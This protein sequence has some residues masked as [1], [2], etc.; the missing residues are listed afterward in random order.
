M[1]TRY[2]SSYRR[3]P[4]YRSRC[5]RRR[6]PAGCLTALTWFLMDL[7]TGIVLILL[8]VCFGFLLIVLLTHLHQVEALGSQIVAWITRYGPLVLLLVSIV[9]GSFLVLGGIYG[10]V[11][12]IV[13][14]SEALSH[15]SIVQARARQEQAN[16]AY[17]A[18]ASAQTVPL[19]KGRFRRSR[20]P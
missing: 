18:F 16:V 19:P 4:V 17:Y 8:T 20:H 1:A 3:Y 11:K 10:L 12:M 6:R 13:A 14:I 15:A 9:A 7:L 5:T 2:R